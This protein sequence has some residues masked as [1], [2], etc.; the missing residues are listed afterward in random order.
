MK[1]FLVFLLIFAMIGVAGAET[2]IIKKGDKDE[3]YLEK[4]SSLY[5]SKESSTIYI[6]YKSPSLLK[7]FK[8]FVVESNPQQSFT[9]EPSAFP[10][11][12]KQYEFKDSYS[13]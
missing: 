12:E 4:D 9:N 5:P 10:Q 8:P 2:L 6:P 13:E 3:I 7:D 1:G 11:Y